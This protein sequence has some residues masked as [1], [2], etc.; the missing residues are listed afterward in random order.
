MADA[1]KVDGLAQFVRGLKKIDADLPKA[2]RVGF[3]DA[4]Q[5]VVDYAQARIPVRSGRARDSIKV[6]STATTVRVATGGTKAPYEPWLDFGGAVGKQRSVTRPFLKNGRYV[7]QALYTKEAE[8]RTA[9]EK[10]L[11]DVCAAAGIEV[12]HA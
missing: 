2:L 5:I 4:A 11:L 3:N 7:Y 9:V 8:I 12:E 6:R 10:A 1:I